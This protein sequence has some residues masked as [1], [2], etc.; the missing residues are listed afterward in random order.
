MKGMAG[1]AALA[2]MIIAAA[3]CGGSDDN[4]SATTADTSSTAA[5]PAPTTTTADNTA[6]PAGGGALPAGV[7][8]ANVTAGE[9][10]FKGGPC[11]ACHGADA[12][13]TAM[14]PD[15]TDNTWLNIDGSYEQIQ[16]VVKTGVA[17]PKDPAHVSPMPPM[18]GA[19]LS[20]QQVSDIAAYIYSMSH[21][22]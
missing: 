18:G 16:Q 17:K 3:A 5:A 22:G 14:A 1:R 12:K 21:K 7:T 8:Q 4:T 10:A 15:L 6:A 20:D 19:Q 9:T 11:I 2:A 13:G